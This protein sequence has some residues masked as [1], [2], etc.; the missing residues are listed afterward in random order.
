M[1]SLCTALV[2]FTILQACSKSEEN[3]S[4]EDSGETE[5]VAMQEKNIPGKLDSIVLGSWI[6]MGTTFDHPPYF[7]EV[8]SGES[9]LINFGSRSTYI[10]MKNG[11]L[12]DSGTYRIIDSAYVFTTPQRIIR[13]TSKMNAAPPVNG[14]HFL[15]LSNDTLSFSHGLG[16]PRYK[17]IT[18]EIPPSN[19]L[20][21]LVIG[22]WKYL[23]SSM[24]H[25][26]FY[27]P[28]QSNDSGVLTFNNLSAYIEIRRGH[29]IDSG[30]YRVMDTTY[31]GGKPIR[32]LYL[33]PKINL[34]HKGY[35]VLNV[36]NDS[37]TYGGGFGGSDYRRM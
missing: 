32:M 11:S 20:D 1:K 30:K 28:A 24:D 7:S 4:I 12:I 35:W 9:Y 26:P 13:F 36:R 34:G 15:Y 19:R 3:R 27:N 16:G 8:K 31:F 25:P 23:G 29:I 33:E 14:I 21:S 22:N 18:G 5:K 2:M 6:L 17:R 10:S 37:L